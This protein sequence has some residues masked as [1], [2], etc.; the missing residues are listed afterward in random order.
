MESPPAAFKR[1][2]LQGANLKERSSDAGAKPSGDRGDRVDPG[3]LRPERPGAPRRRAP[4]RP[5]GRGEL[6]GARPRPAQVQY[7]ASRSEEHTSE[8]QSL[9]RSS[10]AALCF[11]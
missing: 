9:M 11:K 10:S 5:R 8:L 3:A 4:A 2:V 6:H 1:A 7:V